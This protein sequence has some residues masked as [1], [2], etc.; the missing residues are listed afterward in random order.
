MTEIIA[1]VYD[2]LSMVFET[3]L[4]SKIKEIILFGSV[5]RKSFDKKSDIDLFFNVRDK[6]NSKEV[7]EKLKS[8]LKSFEVKAEKTWALKKIKLPINFI[9]GS[10]EDEAWKGLRDEIISSGLLIYGQYKEAPKNLNHNYVFYYSLNN[11]KRKDKMRFIRKMFGYTQA[12]DRK[13]YSQRGFLKEINGLKLGSN[14]ILAP[15][16]EVLKIKKLFREFEIKYRIIE[17]WVRL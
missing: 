5:A 2:F 6:N 13:E 7:E 12:R 3:E 16:H 9:V 10:L 17:T 14:A 11:L 4:E 8:V 1:Y 15:S